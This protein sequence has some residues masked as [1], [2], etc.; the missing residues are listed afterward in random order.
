MEAPLEDLFRS[1]G[2]NRLRVRLPNR[3]RL[4]SSF[5]ATAL[6]RARFCHTARRRGEYFLAADGH[7][8]MELDDRLGVS[9]AAIVVGSAC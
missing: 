6:P 4:G 3:S 1:F 8:L 2:E 9:R 7:Y 5:S